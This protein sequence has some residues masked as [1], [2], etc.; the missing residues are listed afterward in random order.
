M[1]QPQSPLRI[2]L[3]NLRAR[4][5]DW[6]HVIMV[7]MGVMYLSAALKKAFGERVRVEL[8]DVTTFPE[9]TEP[10]QA[11]RDWLQI[12]RPDVVGIRGFS[13]AAGRS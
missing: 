8:F 9:Q 2:G 4:T 5:K 10:D 12:F 13:D 1:D 11:I 7:P 6:H 3:I